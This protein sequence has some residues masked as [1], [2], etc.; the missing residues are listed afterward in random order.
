MEIRKKFRSE[1]CTQDCKAKL[2][3]CLIS[4]SNQA[5]FEIGRIV[6]KLK[7]LGV[8]DNTLVIFMADNGAQ[9]KCTNYES[10]RVIL[11]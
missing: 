3:C 4:H 7:D 8:Y 11:I 5:D 1:D 6:Q 9:S 10:V 2:E